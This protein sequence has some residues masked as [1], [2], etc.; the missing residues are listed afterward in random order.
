MNKGQRAILW[1]AAL[2]VVTTCYEGS[3]V[4]PDTLRNKN[5]RRFERGD[6]YGEEI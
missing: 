6:S 3:E 2:F 4:G 5:L 1:L